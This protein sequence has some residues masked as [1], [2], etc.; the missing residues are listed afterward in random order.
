MMRKEGTVEEQILLEKEKEEEG[1]NKAVRELHKAI[2]RGE[3]GDTTYG[4][5][6]IRLGFENVVAKLR[7]YYDSTLAGSNQKVVQNLLHL[8]ADDM[9]V[10]GYTVLTSCINN[11]INHRPITTTA[12]QIV[13]RLRDIYL[14]NRLKKD[15]P[16][17][18]T[19]LGDKFRRASKTDK[20]RLIKKH[21]QKLYNLGEELEDKA[22]MVRLGTTLINLV[23]L[24][25]ANIIEVKKIMKGHNKTVNVIT[26]TDDAQEIITNLE[27]SDI[28]IGTI[29]KLPMIVEPKD[30]T[31]NYDGGFYRGKNQ[32]FTVKSGDVAKH[33]RKNTYP[34]V[35]NVI[36]KL[37]K[38]A[39]RVNTGVLEVIRHIFDNNMVDPLTPTR[40]PKLF[41]DLPT[42]EK[43]TWQD[44][45]KESDY[46][47]WHDF[48]REREDITIRQNAEN[49]KRL[50]LIYSIAVA[51][52]MKEYATLY[53]PYIMDYRGRVYADVN[54]LT[55]QGQHYTKAMLEFA[56]G[57]KLDATGVR[58]LKIHT[59]NVY[60]KDKEAYDER[61]EWF[62][63][64]EQLIIDISINPLDNLKH[65]VY[66]DSPFEFLAACMA[67]TDH[68][69]GM[70][71]HLPIQLDATCSGI[72]MYS[73]LLRD[74]VGA[75]SVN[76]IGN[77][78][79][80]IY[81][82]VADRVDVHLKNGNYSKW[83]E[84]TDKEGQ[85]KSEYAEPVAKSM[86]GNITRGLVKR[87][88]MTVPYSV[89][90]QG[91]SNQIW[92]KIDE[93]TLKGKEFWTGSR[94][95][96]NKLLTQLN[97]TAIYE[98]IDGAK[99]GQEYLVGI[100]KLL[101]KPATWNGVLYDFPV[102]QTALSLKEKRVKTVYGSLVMNVEI[103]KLNKRRQSN[104]I[105][106]NF[107]HN[108]DSTILLY[109]VEHMAQPIGVIHDCFLVHPNDGSEIQHQ[110]KEGFITVMEADPLR[111]I[112]A[113]LDPEGVVEFPEYGELDLNQV[114]DSDYIIS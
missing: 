28:P 10:V 2:E 108:I 81:Q 90:R 71:V 43:Y 32:L 39:W 50:E 20:Q 105:A 110:Y 101:D 65:W 85:T 52:R 27:Y 107:V 89:T 21:I 6:L 11:S 96:A 111:N 34:K 19:Y 51:E 69:T 75:E 64:N 103:P 18:H 79:N 37:Q 48:N 31:N 41:G 60:G 87:N 13:T 76:V 45:I 30:W 86:I 73:G 15:N 22:L 55:P 53:Y 77:K 12:N 109:C 70:P 113:Q 56:D 104:S 38:T 106:P 47:K 100:S 82:M 99:K 49:T 102:R 98:I 54:F 58:W 7:E 72:Q 17:L 4:Q 3:F 95:V 92:D 36:N 112:Q 46:E 33:L 59:A 66:A 94:W 25:G 5:V 80:D 67:W 62:D 42:R 44:F 93:A 63:N 26:L 35:Y 74:K 40:A 1:V 23:E 29:N 9:E 68:K 61:I 8:I 84:Y 78:R 83:I 88:V 24:S 57:R 16:K 114:R 97:H 14:V 91:M